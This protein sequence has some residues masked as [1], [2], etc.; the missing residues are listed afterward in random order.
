MLKSKTLRTGSVPA[1]R[2]KKKI[3][4]KIGLSFRN[5]LRNTSVLAVF[6]GAQAIFK[7]GML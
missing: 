1:R 4:G 2:L 3:M 6:R 7:M 5:P